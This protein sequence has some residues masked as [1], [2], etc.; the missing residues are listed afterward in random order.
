MQFFGAFNEQPGSEIAFSRSLQGLV[1]KRVH[2]IIAAC[3]CAATQG[4]ACN[5]VGNAVNVEGRQL[6]NRCQFRAGHALGDSNQP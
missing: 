1:G 2:H 3:C 4:A 5:V 6:R